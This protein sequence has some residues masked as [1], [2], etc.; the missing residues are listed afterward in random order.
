MGLHELLSLKDKIALVTG[1]SRG[2]GQGFA[3]ALAEAGAHLSI[4]SRHRD[5]LTDTA[6][7]VKG[8]GREVLSLQV[9]VTRE[10]DVREMVAKTVERYG[11]IDILVNN[12]ATERRNIPPEETSLES[13]S[14]VIDTNLNGPFLCAR[15]VGKVMIPRKRG[16]IINIASMSG[17]IINRYF[18]GGSYDVSKSAVVGLTKALAVEW[19]K[20]NV[21]VIAVAPGYYGT[22]P[23]QKWFEANP[24]IRQRVIDMIPLNRL[25]K[26][27][28]LAALVT[29]LASDVSNYMTG[30]TVVIDG[31]YTLW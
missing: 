21:N 9:D 5:E 29:V 25:G 22:A 31:G 24:E 7:R 4:V 17:M 8:Y 26:I 3:A 23:N 12:A 2:L 14:F 18:H 30:S 27:E 16:K 11:H 28:E 10:A 13:W 6:E 20:H 19:A 15:E 1:A